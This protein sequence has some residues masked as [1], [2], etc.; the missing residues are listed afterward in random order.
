M[1][2]IYVYQSLPRTTHAY[3]VCL[4]LLF[5]AVQIAASILVHMISIELS[6]ISLQTDY[7]YYW[8]TRQ[9]IQGWKTTFQEQ[10]EFQG[11]Q[12]RRGYKLTI[13]IYYLYLHFFFCMMY[14]NALRIADMREKCCAPCEISVHPVKAWTEG[15]SDQIRTTENFDTILFQ[16]IQWKYR[17][18]TKYRHYSLD[19]FRKRNTGT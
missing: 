19:N 16:N 8:N 5:L 13:F 1:E 12:S 10:E 15:G 6:T 17:R 11:R 3:D 18:Q 2:C 9:S 4:H 7:Y 14:E